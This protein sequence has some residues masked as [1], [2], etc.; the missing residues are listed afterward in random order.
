MTDKHHFVRWFYLALLALA[1]AVYAV[2]ILRTGIDHE[3]HRVFTLVDDAMISMR[4]ARHLAAGQGLVWNVGEPP[5]Q[6]FT[7]LAWTLYMALWHRIGLSPSQISM[8]IMLTSAGALLA[9]V[10]VVRRLGEELAPGAWLA[11]AL[12]ATLTA[13][14][15]PLVFWSLRGMEVGVLCL[16]LNLSI[17]AALKARRNLG[18][19]HVALLAAAAL[20]AVSVRLDVLAPLAVVL[21]YFAWQ[22]FKQ[23]RPGRGLLV[24]GTVALGV[25]LLLA[26]NRWY[27]GDTLP[28]TY[29]LKVGGFSLATRVSYALKA[30]MSVGIGDIALPLIVALAGLALFRDLRHDRMALVGGVFLAA[31]AYSIYVGGDYAEYQVRG[32]NRFLILGVAPLFLLGATAAGRFASDLRSLDVGK[33]QTINRASLAVFLFVSVGALLTVSGGYWY[34]W[35]VNNAPFIVSDTWRMKLG[36]LLSTSTDPEAVIAVHAA[37]QIPYYADRRTV[38]LLG[39]SDRVIAHELP[40]A[41]FMPGHSKWDYAYSIGQLQPD[42]VADELTATAPFMAGLADS[43]GRLGNGLWVR[44]SSTA[45][46]HSAVEGDY[47]YARRDNTFCD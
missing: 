6:G 2:F 4:F 20:A 45:V 35:R 3:G 17:L 5:V 9:N 33:L 29:Y 7:N 38:D 39:K 24:I 28:N 13:F 36:L 37:G 16:L 23:K 41:P 32:A 19:G 22:A 21:A 31:F 47:S 10:W 27:F 34:L 46:D 15:F 14:Y 18:W 1:A 26:F 40:A 11:P 25:L 30:L 42:V 8:A 12:A 43:Y 44:N